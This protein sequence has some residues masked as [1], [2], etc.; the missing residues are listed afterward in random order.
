MT[1]KIVKMKVKGVSKQPLDKSDLAQITKW[2][3]S[4]K[5]KWLE[6]LNSS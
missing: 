2:Q 3:S 1:I 5:K 6:T 4:D